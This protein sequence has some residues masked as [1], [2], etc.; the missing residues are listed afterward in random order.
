[1]A[2]DVGNRRHGAVSPGNPWSMTLKGVKQDGIMLC[3]FDPG[4]FSNNLWRYAS[5]I[6][7]SMMARPAAGLKLS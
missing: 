1:M 7:A 3:L 4:L 6:T 2:R 5:T